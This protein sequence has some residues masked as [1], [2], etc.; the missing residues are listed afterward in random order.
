M[1]EYEGSI[2]RVVDG[3]T[4]I[5]KGKVVDKSALTGFI[6]IQVKMYR[7]NDECVFKGL[8]TVK[9]LPIKI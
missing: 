8:G 7:Q 9:V 3:D 5:V 1:F 6:D 2:E 4:I